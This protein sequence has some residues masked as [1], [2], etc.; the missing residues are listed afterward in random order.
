INVEFAY[1]FGGELATVAETLKSV[2][3]GDDG[4]PALPG[5]STILLYDDL[6]TGAGNTK[7]KYVFR[8]TSSEGSGTNVWATLT[9]VGGVD[10]LVPHEQDKDSVDRQDIWG[11][12]IVGDIITWWISDGKWLAFRVTSI[13]PRPTTRFKFGIILIVFDETDGTGNLSLTSGV[14]V[15][16]RLSRALRG[17][18]GAALVTLT[19]ASISETKDPTAHAEVRTEPDGFVYQRTIAGGVVAINTSTDWI[20]PHEEAPGGYEIRATAT[21]DALDS[22]SDVLNT[23]LAMNVQRQWWIETTIGSKDAVVTLTIRHSAQGGNLDSG[24]FTLAVSD[25]A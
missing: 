12:I 24:V 16:L 22:G 19:N 11:Q 23:W 20:I 8:T 3:G 6:D 21:G 15:E 1:S 10:F 7:G 13:E 5:A 17:E 9:T 14:D 2:Q 4:R 18:S 25:T